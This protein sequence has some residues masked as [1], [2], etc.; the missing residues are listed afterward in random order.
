MPA[1][2]MVLRIVLPACLLSGCATFQDFMGGRPAEPAVVLPPLAERE[3]LE[4][5]SRN[6]FVLEAEDLSVVGEPQIVFTR[7]EDTFSDLAR[8]YGLG[9]DE[10]VAANPGIDPWLP[11]AGVPILL[12]TQHVLP[13]AP[14]RGIVLNIAAKR[15]FYY[16]E[17]EEGEK[18]VV[19]T[20][21]IGIGRVGWETPTGTAK[22][23]AKATDPHWYVPWSVQQEHREAGDPLPA[24]VPPGPDNPLGRHVL[25]LNM[26]G[27]LIHGTNMPYGVGMR[28]SHGCV[29]M[30]PE[31]IELLHS[32]VPVGEPVHLVNQPIL[33]GTLDGEIFLESHPVLEDDAISRDAHLEALFARAEPNKT[34]ET[35]TARNHARAIASEALGLPVRISAADSMELYT[36]A[37]VVRNTVKTD[38]D[39][40]TLAEVRELLDALPERPATAGAVSTPA[41]TAREQAKPQDKADE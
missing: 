29:R 19:M 40:P 38:P 23:V 3:E 5:I 18:P 8:E 37:R 30:Y 39:A 17:V 14:R 26:P 33:S 32:L 24:V 20:Y 21:P 22:V 6:Y 31:N 34:F 16:P 36:R 28:V 4:P 2:R 12:P 11:G 41:A 1:L 15:L 35:D 9:Y 10:L 27:Y 25:Q 7:E 13:D